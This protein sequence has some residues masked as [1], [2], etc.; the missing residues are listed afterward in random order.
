[1]APSLCHKDTFTPLVA[2]CNFEQ[3][4]ELWAMGMLGT[5]GNFSWVLTGLVPACAVLGAPRRREE[6]SRDS[7]LGVLMVGSGEAGAA[8]DGSSDGA[9]SRASTKSL[10]R[11]PSPSTP[12]STAGPSAG[13]RS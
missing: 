10:T 5:V 13:G 9:M 1:M 6:S 3:M 4:P 7:I 11:T 2:F 12:S 8:R